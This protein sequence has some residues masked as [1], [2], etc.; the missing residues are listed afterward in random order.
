M[1]TINRYELDSPG[2]NYY[3]AYPSFTHRNNATFAE[4]HLK[5]M[6]QCSSKVAHDIL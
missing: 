5:I 2:M 4:I 1:I 3:Y 6:L